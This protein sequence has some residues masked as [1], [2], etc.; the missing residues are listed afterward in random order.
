VRERWLGSQAM[1]IEQANQTLTYQLIFII[2]AGKCCLDKAAIVAS[3]RIR[4]LM[5]GSFNNTTF[6]GGAGKAQLCRWHDRRCFYSLKRKLRDLRINDGPIR[7]EGGPFKA[8]HLE[9]VSRRLASRTSKRIWHAQRLR[10]Y[11]SSTVRSLAGPLVILRPA[12]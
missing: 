2:T 1:P 9:R 12:T 4:W 3:I 5:R 10:G 11:S 7:P 8:A 6:A